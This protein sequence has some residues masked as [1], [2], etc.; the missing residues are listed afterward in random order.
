MLSDEAKR[1]DMYVEMQSICSKDG[2]V[3]VPMFANYVFG[4]STNVATPE[5]LAGNWEL[6]GMKAAE[7]WWF[8]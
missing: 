3:V 2:G 7:R 6:D 1:R 4:T 8:A 5:K